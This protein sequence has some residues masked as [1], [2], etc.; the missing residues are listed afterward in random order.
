M[1][2]FRENNFEGEKKGGVSNI[3]TQRKYSSRRYIS[4]KNYEENKY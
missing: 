1:I 3:I 4:E 2:Y